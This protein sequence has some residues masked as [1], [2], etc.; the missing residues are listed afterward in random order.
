PAERSGVPG[1][2]RSADIAK[3]SGGGDASDS[4]GVAAT[5]KV[6]VLAVPGHRARGNRVRDIGAVWRQADTNDEV[7]A[8]TGE[9]SRRRTRFSRESEIHSTVRS[10]RPARGLQSCCEAAYLRIS[11]QAVSGIGCKVR[12]R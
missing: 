8:L 1:I 7:L 12:A 5:A 10:G 3:I 6:A 9:V 2:G 4:A 11:G